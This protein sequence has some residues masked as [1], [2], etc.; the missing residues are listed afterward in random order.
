MDNEFEGVELAKRA[1][2]RK[3]A[4]ERQKK[5]RHRKMTYEVKEMYTQD[6][7]LERIMYGECPECGY[8]ERKVL[9]VQPL[10]AEA[11]WRI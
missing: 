2:E 10:P 9:Y 11:M 6:A 5:C 7:R 4:W 1:I 8:S 3:A